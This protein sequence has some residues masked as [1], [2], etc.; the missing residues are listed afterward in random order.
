MDFSP[1]ENILATYLYSLPGAKVNKNTAKHFEE[2]VIPINQHQVTT[3][4][5]LPAP[6]KKFPILCDTGAS[7]PNQGYYESHSSLYTYPTY[8]V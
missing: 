7:K 4:H 1:E 5:F 6:H 8:D 2:A 3:G